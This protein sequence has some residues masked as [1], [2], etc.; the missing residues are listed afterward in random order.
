TREQ[1][2]GAMQD[3]FNGIRHQFNDMDYLVAFNPEQ[4]KSAVGNTGL[5]SSQDTDIRF[6]RQANAQ[7]IIQNLVSNMNK[8]GR[9]KLKTEAGYKATHA[10]Q[11]VLGA[12]GRRQLTE[13]Y[14][15]L[16]PQLKPYNDMVAMMD[17]DQN[18]VAALSDDL[19]RRWAD[20]KD[21]K[22][23]ANVMHDATLAKIDPAKPYQ[24]G[25]SVAEYAKLKK[26]FDVLSDD[27]KKVYREARDA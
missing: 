8:Q 16:L 4:V 22:E 11:Y 15:K 9:N 13:L 6:S 14:Q 10:L 1:I 18:E 7:Q 2:V 26:Q 12:L 25:D 20:L 3:G 24:P 27:A 19:A 23:L 5:F 17:A 21:E